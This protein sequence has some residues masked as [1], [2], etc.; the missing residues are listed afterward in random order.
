MNG[1]SGTARSQG[2]NINCV[3]SPQAGPQHALVKCPLPLIFFGGARGGGKTDS[4]LGKWGYKALKLGS[5]FNAVLF[6]R[7]LPMLDDVIARSKELYPLIGGKFNDQRKTWV[8]QNGARIR[9]RPLRMVVDADKYQGQN[10]SDMCI[11]EAGQYPD[12]APIDRL[13]GAL[14]SAAGA[15]TQ[16]LLTGNPGGSGQFWLKARFIDPAPAGM[17]IQEWKIGKSV[18]PWVFIPSKVQNNQILLRNDPTYVDRLHLVGNDKLV[19]AW[20]EGDWNAV[21]GAFFGEWETSRHVIQPFVVPSYWTRFMAFD[22]GSASPFACLWFAVSDGTVKGVPKNALVVY[23]EWYGGKLDRGRYV[24]LKL[25]TEAVAQGIVQ[26][27]KGEKIDYA[28]A[29]PA[30]FSED[31][32]PSR[33]EVFRRNGVVFRPADNRRVAGY[34]H[35]GGWD[36]VRY[37]LKGI[38]G[39]PLVFFFNTCSHIIRTLPVLQHDVNR[40]EDLDTDSDD[41]APDAL[42]YGCMSRPRAKVEKKVEQQRGWKFEDLLQENVVRLRGKQ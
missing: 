7:E 15:N 2:R 11:E 35:L 17:A 26:R 39:V 28:V 21:E 30:I 13:F 42:R 40:P 1:Q 4:V 16:M 20:L 34:G 38:D 33:A 18:I 37:R 9:F 10:I 19:Q 14:R 22:W 25:T 23:R 29:D 36:E 5:A 41:H 24:G 3:W 27:Q 32:G 31:G 6:R 8:F 12:P